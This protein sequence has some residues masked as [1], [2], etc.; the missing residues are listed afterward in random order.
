MRAFLRRAYELRSGAP[1]FRG[2]PVPR[3]GIALT[4]STRKMLE[5]MALQFDA[6]ADRI[7]ALKTLKEGRSTG[8]CCGGDQPT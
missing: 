3:Y 6:E 7:E 8:G 1:A 4:A 2:E 5:E